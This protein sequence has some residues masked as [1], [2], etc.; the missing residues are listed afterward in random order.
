MLRAQFILK[1]PRTGS[2]KSAPA[3]FSWTTLLFGFLVPIYRKDWLWA[4]IILLA[5]IPTLGAASI[6]F[7]FFYNKIYAKNL[8]KNGYT[9]F[10]MDGYIDRKIVNEYLGFQD[11]A[12][13]KSFTEADE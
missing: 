6:P 9:F 11:K 7:A 4:V 1:N 5:E 10:S 12:F 13:D 2:I 3:G 8:F